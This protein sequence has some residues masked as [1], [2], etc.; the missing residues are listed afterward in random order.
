MFIELERTLAPE[1]MGNTRCAAC[2]Q[3]FELGCVTAW[4]MSDVRI[5]LGFICPDCLK[6]GADWIEQKIVKRHEVDLLFHEIAINQCRAISSESMAECPSVE[7]YRTLE[8]VYGTPRYRNGDE[9]EAA[10]SRGE[11]PLP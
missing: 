10:I 3:D 6:H 11:W 9:A 5:H 1:D 7:E 8:K 4:M 2:N